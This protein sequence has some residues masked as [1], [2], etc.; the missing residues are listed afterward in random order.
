MKRLFIEKIVGLF[1]IVKIKSE[2]YLC[3]GDLKYIFIFFMLFHISTFN[4]AYLIF[5]LMFAHKSTYML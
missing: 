4:S 1:K 5:H 2:E 3:E